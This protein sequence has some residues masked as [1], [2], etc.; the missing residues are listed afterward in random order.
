MGIA[1]NPA[2]LEYSKI[3]NIIDELGRASHKKEGRE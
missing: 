1:F 3:L 2:S